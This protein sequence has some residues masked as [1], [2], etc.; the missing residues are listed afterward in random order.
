[1]LCKK[2]SILL[3][4]SFI[5]TNIS[6]LNFVVASY[7]DKFKANLSYKYFKSSA[8]YN[9]GIPAD[10]FI[11]NKSTSHFPCFLIKLYAFTQCSSNY[12]NILLFYP[13][14]IYYIS[15]V[16]TNFARS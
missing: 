6:N 13:S 7:S 15:E 12:L 2:L 4:L 3:Q 8:L 14:I 1:M 11:K 16:N 9:S 5:E 10:K